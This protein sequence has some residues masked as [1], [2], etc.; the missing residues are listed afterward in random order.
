VEVVCRI[1]YSQTMRTS[2]VFLV[3]LAAQAQAPPDPTDVLARARDIVLSRVDRLPNYTCVQTINRNYFKASSAP[4]S[5]DK[6]IGERIKKPPSQQ[7]EATDRLRLDVKVSEGTEVGSWAGANKFDSRSIVDIV[8]TGP[9]GTGPFGTLMSDIFSNDGASFQYMGKASGNEATLLEYRFQVPLKSSHYLIRAGQ[10]WVPTAY[11]GQI[12]IDSSSFEVKRL[13]VRTGE[14]PP[15]TQSCE[16]TSAVDYQIMKVGTGEALIPHVSVLHFLLRDGSENES[17]TTYSNCHEFHGESTIHFEDM[18][19]TAAA[20]AKAAEA[21]V[22]PAGVTVILT[23]ETPIDSDTAA[24]GDII[25]AKVSKNVYFGK[26]K[27]VAI[28]ADAL[29]RGRLTLM[30]HRIGENGRF[31]IGILLE[32][33]EIKG[34]ETPFYAKLDRSQEIANAQRLERGGL[35]HGANVWLPPPGQSPMVG[36]FVFP[37]SNSRYVVPRGYEFRW[38]TLPPPPDDAPK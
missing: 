5:C 24:A 2:L 31:E 13:R 23:L 37:T 28:P 26:H 29:V 15:E 8:E 27:E 18:P 12:W 32:S 14:L 36:N 35:L 16:A 19:E 25:E 21:R 34:A 3:T 11:D 33:I 20:G 9:I 10:S 17:I 22:I 38:L 4:A 6:M 30:Q 1:D 7:L